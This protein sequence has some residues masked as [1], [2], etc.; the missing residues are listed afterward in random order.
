[1]NKLDLEA[2]KKSIPTFETQNSKGPNTNLPTELASSITIKQPPAE[3]V[4]SYKDVLA[5]M[6]LKQDEDDDEEDLLAMKKKIAAQKK[7]N[8]GGL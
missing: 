6:N 2:L 4:G 3:K 8:A 1:M 7:K 5:S